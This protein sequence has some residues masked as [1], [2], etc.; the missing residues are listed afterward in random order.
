MG[1]SYTTTAEMFFG[2]DRNILPVTEIVCAVARKLF[3]VKTARNLASRAGTTHRAAE[4]WLAQNT[5][6]SAEALAETL[7]SDIGREVLEGLMGDAHPS[8][9]PA[10]KADLVFADLERRE[11]ANREAIEELRREIHARR[12]R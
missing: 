4:F 12:A 6:M 3:P 11:T 8:W 2:K 9:W 1:R 7:R 10:F 5:G